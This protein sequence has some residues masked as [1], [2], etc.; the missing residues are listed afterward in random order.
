MSSNSESGGE[1]FDHS[2]SEFW[3]LQF[4]GITFEKNGKNE[5]IGKNGQILTEIIQFWK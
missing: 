4:C 3:I 2:N 1:I 5:N